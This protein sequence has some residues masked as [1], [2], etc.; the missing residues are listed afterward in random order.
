MW[1]NDYFLSYMSHL[2]LWDIISQNL[3]HLE[4]SSHKVF[5]ISQN[6]QTTLQHILWRNK[7]KSHFVVFITSFL[8]LDKGI[9]LFWGCSKAIFVKLS[10]NFIK[11]PLTIW[12]ISHI[13][14]HSLWHVCPI[15]SQILMFNFVFPITRMSFNSSYCIKSIAACF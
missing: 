14:V 10:Q 3:A 2:T 4:A 5:Q 13:S 6:F 8:Y 12:L 7:Y 9:W 11:S 1:L 15:T